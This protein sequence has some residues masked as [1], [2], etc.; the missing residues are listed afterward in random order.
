[1]LG[2]QCLSVQRQQWLMLQHGSDMPKWLAFHCIL[3]LVWSMS[4]FAQQSN[5]RGWIGLRIQQVT[6]DIADAMNIKPPRGALVASVDESGPAKTAG[7]EPGDV[8]VKFDNREIKEMHDLPRIVADTPVGKEVKVIVIRAGNEERHTIIVSRVADAPSQSQPKPPGPNVGEQFPISPPANAPGRTPSAS[9]TPVAPN[10]ATLPYQAEGDKAVVEVT[11]V[12][13]TLSEARMD[14][15]RQALQRTMQQLVVVDRLIKDDKVVIDKIYSSLNGYVENVKEVEVRQDTNSV[16]IKAEVTVSPT[17]IV[18]FAKIMGGATTEISGGSILGEAQREIEAR[19][20]RG[21]MFA[22]LFRGVPNDAFDLQTNVHPAND[23]P[24]LLELT[25]NIRFNM[26]WYRQFR[27][28]LEAL[29]QKTA[30][31]SNKGSDCYGYTNA[32]WQA[33]LRANSSG[34]TLLC[35]R[36]NDTHSL[37]WLRAG[38]YKEGLDRFYVIVKGGAYLPE[39]GAY[40]PQVLVLG[41][42]NKTQSYK[43]ECFVYDWHAAWTPFFGSP[44]PPFGLEFITATNLPRGSLALAVVDRSLII[45]IPIAKIDLSRSEQISGA[46]LLPVSSSK[47]KTDAF[48]DADELKDVCDNYVY[49]R[50]LHQ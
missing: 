32:E 33:A 16:A 31:V 44:E 25:V 35:V 18:N 26:K 20:V 23:N 43:S 14:A 15:I 19:A 34:G 9:M 13:A 46:L 45:K 3:L 12:G 11:G 24:Q 2:F 36:D 37:Y 28:G 50:A 40:L 17:R 1:M 21:E 7:I 39:G 38:N 49:R 41:F 42:S 8:I 27:A 29:G 48:D 10:I 22:R 6:G 30:E 4:A 47:V 5:E